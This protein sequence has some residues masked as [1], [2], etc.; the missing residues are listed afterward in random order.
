MTISPE[1]APAIEVSPATVRKLEAPGFRPVGRPLMTVNPAGIVTFKPF[2]GPSPTFFKTNFTCGPAES[3]LAEP[4]LT[5]VPVVS[6][7]VPTD[8]EIEGSATV[9][10]TGMSNEGT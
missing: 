8:T 10:A 6:V 3:R 2:N 9:H 4:K 1:R 7:V 5:G